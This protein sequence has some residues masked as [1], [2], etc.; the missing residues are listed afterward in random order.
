MAKLNIRNVN[1]V[2]YAVL[3]VGALLTLAAWRYTV[4][5]VERS[6]R[7]QFD[8]RAGQV[9]QALDQRMQAYTDILYGLQGFF[10]H[11]DG[12]TSE[13]FHRYIEKTHIRDRYPGIQAIGF[14]PYLT[15]DGK[16]AFERNMREDRSLK[17][18][19]Y[20]VFAIHPPG[21][22]AEY[23]PIAYLEPLRGNEQAFGFDI[24]SESERRES[25]LRA[26]DTGLAAASGPLT[27][28]QETGKQ[29]GFL[30]SVP[31]YRQNVPLGTVEQRRQA[32]YGLVY[33]AF[34][35]GDLVHGAVPGAMLN[36]VG[37]RI[38]DYGLEEGRGG[39]GGTGR[40]LF[41]LQEAVVG[42]AQQQ[43]RLDVGGRQWRL[44]LTAK[45]PMVAV[46]ELRRP[47]WTLVFGMVTTLL[48]FT[49]VQALSG[50]RRRAMALA[51]EMTLK[52]RESETR[53]R[54]VLDNVLDGVVTIDEKGIV[55]SFN[56]SA[57]RIF[58]Y[59]AEEMIG[60][61]VNLLMPEPY[62]GRHDDYLAA[63]CRTGH[64]KVIG[65]GREVQGQRK[66]GE[67]FPMDLS[68]T[69]MQ[70]GRLRLFVGLVRDISSSRQVEEELRTSQA[71][72]AQAQQMAHIGNWS[73]DLATD[74]LK[75]SDEAYRIFGHDPQAFVPTLEILRQAVH[76]DDRNA[77]FQALDHAIKDGVPFAME[78]RVVLPNGSVR[79]VSALGE[80]VYG[81]DGKP[82]QMRGTVQDITE[83]KMAQEEIGRFKN[84]LDNTL[85][86]IFMFDPESLRIV[87]LNK[88]M[89]E[90]LGYSRDELLGMEAYEIKPLMPEQVFRS[91]I[92]PLISGDRQWLS[93]ETMH[94]RKDGSDVPVEEFLQ[95]VRQKDG[96]G[97]FVAVA[98]DLTE[99]RR[100]DKLKSEFISTVSHELRT[101]MTSIRGSLGLVM[102]GVAG[103]LPA[104]AKSMVEIAYNNSERLVRLINDILDMD[105]IESGKMRLDIRTVE[106]LPL[107]E[108]S[109]EANRAYGE[110]FGVKFLL[111]G[112]DEGIRVRVDSDRLLQVMANLMSNAAKFSPSGGEVEISVAAGE[113]NVRVAV[114]DHGPGIPQE[115]RERIFRKFSQADSSDT[116]RKGGTGLGL[117]I[118]KALVERMNGGIGFTS[119]EGDGS[120]F[121][122]DLPLA[123]GGLPGPSPRLLVCED[124]GDVAMQLKQMLAR[125]GYRVDV[126]NS[127]EAAKGLLARNTYSAM[128]LDLMLPGQ[129]GLSLVR[130][131]QAEG[132]K[133]PVVV[134]S[135]VAGERRDASLSVLEWLEKPVRA[136]RLLEVLK[137]GALPPPKPLILHVEDEEDIRR[138]LQSLLGG[139]AEVVGVGTKAEAQTLLA[140]KNFDLVVLDIGLPDGSGLEVL[141]FM[142]ARRIAIPVVLFSAHETGPEVN[143]RAA[144]TLVK[145]RASNKELE[146][147]IHRVME[148]R[149][150]E[151]R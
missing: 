126:A 111:C 34:R 88:G 36:Q 115:F 20:P 53:V 35:M 86:M 82:L 52:L 107:L 2:A 129:D 102:G 139:D 11:R 123:K 141:D 51:E 100:V 109:L 22:R 92:A 149:Y 143:S 72:F 140:Q 58:G 142:E 80:V 145:S 77:L 28:V 38:S 42:R 9:V 137:N 63:Y 39:T 138:V 68:V 127:A 108:Q 76:G 56:R 59:S 134:I 70:V 136:D 46:S 73:W 45:A 130:E 97:L 65:I 10:L 125:H 81:N 5:E 32:F 19:G 105:K 40:S 4:D 151:K 16:A 17:A 84:V 15:A 103:E 93:Y 14:V 37:L 79:H 120:T 50:S 147:T 101:P 43:A 110:Q 135:A 106:L 116:R 61:N 131:L 41:A 66:D 27:L 87:Y 67:I 8:F 24:G 49:V 6:E 89:E 119:K 112:G 48:L 30:L 94:R 69:E 1:L 95:M 83:R 31:L 133:V 99:R 33:I 62:R 144:A 60:R 113:K 96:Q 114:K 118:C 128:T 57:E 23:Y 90:G 47:W 21:E 29:T 98:R 71:N 13:A 124:N 26:R 148:R 117:S 85:D 104:Q 75:W 55:N 3:V 25:V 44:D 78:H 12:V 132:L 64:K 146:E 7:Y 150:G 74:S 54:A 91:H 18:R 121:F 122:F